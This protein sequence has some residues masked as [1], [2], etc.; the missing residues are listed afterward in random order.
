MSVLEQANTLAR[1][2]VL[3]KYE[4]YADG[5]GGLTFIFSGDSMWD[6]TPI[7][8]TGRV[9][10]VGLLLKELVAAQEKSASDEEDFEVGADAS[11]E[12]ECWTLLLEARAAYLEWV[13]AIREQEQELSGADVSEDAAVRNTAANAT[14][15]MEQILTF[16]VK[17]LS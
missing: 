14:V 16:Q 9:E 6:K 13:S 8:L 2:L 3:Q 12:R 5:G 1:H 15:A 7:V 11:R 10:A 17:V 4:G